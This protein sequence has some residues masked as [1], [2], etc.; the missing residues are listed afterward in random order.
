[1]NA[2]S[3]L[4]NVLYLP[5]VLLQ[6]TRKLSALLIRAFQQPD[7]TLQVPLLAANALNLWLS[8]ASA[9]L[10]ASPAPRAAVAVR[11]QLQES[12]LLQHL[13][14]AMDAAAAWLT[15]AALAALAGA[16]ATTGSSSSSTAGASVTQQ[17]SSPLQHI[18]FHV[19]ADACCKYL[20]QIFKLASCVVSPT[21]ALQGVLPAAPAAVRMALT[22]FQIHDKLQQLKQQRDTGSPRVVSSQAL[23]AAINAIVTVTAS[24]EGDFEVPSMLRSCPAAS[25]LVQMAEFVSCLAIMAVAIAMGVDT[26]SGGIASAA[27]TPAAS[28]SS[29]ASSSTSRRVPG[30]GRQQPPTQQAAS[31][32]DRCWAGSSGS[33]R[34]GVSSSGGASSNSSGLSNGVRLDNLTPLSCSLFD[35]LGVNQQTV[36]LFARLANADNFTRPQHLQ[37]LLKMYSIVLVYQVSM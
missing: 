21:L 31:G 20:L 22:V 7:P 13:G 8:K 24:F 14:P 30:A 33:G 36:L 3:R 27:A 1:M 25:A 9:A 16:A 19:N 26:S 28:S 6:V 15:T 18:T 32:S 17:P 35:I 10:A 4:V 37:V 29:G 11:Q 23:R 12:Q 34:G 5:A 2:V